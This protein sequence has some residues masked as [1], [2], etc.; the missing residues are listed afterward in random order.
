MPAFTGKASPLSPQGFFAAKDINDT[1]D[2]TL[3]SILSV[4]TSGC[5]YLPDRRPKILFERHYFSRL[6]KGRYDSSHPDISA[7]NYGGYGEGGAHQYSRLD[8]AIKLDKEA[9]LKSASWGL[10]QIMGENFQ[11]AGF[12]SVTTMVDAMVATEDAQLKCIAKFIEAKGM[13]P[14][15]RA[16]DWAGFAKRYNGPNYAQN[17]YDTKLAQFYEQYSAGPMPD[18]LIRAAQFYLTF[19]GYKPGPIDGLKGTATTNA[20]KAFQAKTGVPQTGIIDQK[21]ID[22]LAKP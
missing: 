21:L 11:A 1:E 16:R 15:L 8:T 22:A 13:A 18:L 5:G 14:F 12:I 7:P 17:Q 4:E 2:A 20:V 3:W 9:A 19:K 10:G 6:T